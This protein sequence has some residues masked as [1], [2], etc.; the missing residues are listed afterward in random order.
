MT[1]FAEFEA[2]FLDALPGERSNLEGL[3]GAAE[4]QLSS[5]V[6][7]LFEHC[8]G[9]TWNEIMQGEGLAIGSKGGKQLFLDLRVSIL[10]SGLIFIE[11]KRLGRFSG[12]QG[13]AALKDATEQL[14]AYI[15]TH[16][17]QASSKPQAAPQ[18]VL[19]VVTDG[20]HWRLIGLDTKNKFY[21]V[22][23]WAL[24]TD[25]PRRLAQRMWLLAKPALARPTPALVEFL[26]RRT[27][28]EVL[29]AR[30]KWLTAQVNKELPG[31]AVSQ[32][33]ISRWLRDA[34]ADPAAAP[35]L[36][37]AESSSA[38]STEPVAPQ[39]GPGAEEKI[40]GGVTL[41]GLIAA[42]ILKPPLK[43]FRRY[44]GQEVEADL[45]P[46]GQIVF[47][48]VA[49][50]SCSQ[51]GEVARAHITGHAMN[52]NGWTFWQYRDAA[53]HRLRLDDARKLLVKNKQGQQDGLVPHDQAERHDLRKKFWEGLLSRPKVQGT[54]HAGLAPVQYGWISASSGLKGLSFVYVIKQHAGRFELWID[55]GAGK[56]A[57]NKDIFDGLQ[58]HQADIE[59][60]FGAA[61]SWQR[62]DGK[63]GSRIA[64]DLPAGGYQSEE[65]K[66]P[67]I[68]DAMID[69]MLR[70]EAALGPHLD[71]LKTELAS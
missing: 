37:P 20:N 27:L 36:V 43:L 32:E 23:E 17:N 69:A 42:G 61:L 67:A 65:A 13:A 62:L 10:N 19:G 31:G 45:L 56:A 58:K 47:K 70:L 2:P 68:Q 7:H 14:H 24:L 22:A 29:Q 6:R 25:D 8:L 26:A 11:C 35:G 48:G 4:A 66:W 54:R 16:L 49:Y 63:Q 9:Y 60:A 71:K 18:T 59:K 44:K 40:A 5:W 55:R 50:G 53:G 1:S 30:T 39:P 21:T 41:A 57:E 38:A 33:V 12:P 15:W 34:F 46:D 52:T 28:A 64:Y 51:A 3:Q